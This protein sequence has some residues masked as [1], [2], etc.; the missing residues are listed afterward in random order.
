M[1]MHYLTL[2]IFPIL[3]TVL[4]C[5]SVGR[6]PYE[7]EDYD[8]KKFVHTPEPIWTYNTTSYGNLPCRVDVMHNLTDPFILFHRSYFFGITKVTNE[9]MGAFSPEHENA[10]FVGPQDYDP[11][12]DLRIKNS[13]TEFGPDIDCVVRFNEIGQQGQL[14]YMPNCQYIIRTNRF[15]ATF[16]K[17]DRQFYT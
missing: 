14:L 17:N 13:S 2:L 7:T 6:S 12:F 8:I 16:V 4:Q 5:R 9:M 11:W 1:Q 3:I 15:E 10:M